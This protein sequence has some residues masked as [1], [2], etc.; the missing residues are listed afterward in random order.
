MELYLSH[1]QPDLHS[2]V[3]WGQMHKTLLRLSFIWL[4]FKVH[5]ARTFT[6]STQWWEQAGS[7]CN[8]WALWLREQILIHKKGEDKKKKHSPAA[9]IVC[10]VFVEDGGLFLKGCHY[11]QRAIEMCSKVVLVAGFICASCHG[12][13][14]HFEKLGIYFVCLKVEPFPTHLPQTVRHSQV[15]LVTL[16]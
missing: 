11:E 6:H 8:S 4:F 13:R 3:L 14:C 12:P 2:Q 1:T 5:H 7:G 10:S 16:F 9:E 15:Q